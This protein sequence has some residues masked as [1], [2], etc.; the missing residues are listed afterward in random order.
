M[1]V[2]ARMYVC[3]HVCVCVHICMCVYVHGCVCVYISKHDKLLYS[4]V[5]CVDAAIR[6]IQEQG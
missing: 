6:A 1:C 2:C 4:Y 3:V 5:H